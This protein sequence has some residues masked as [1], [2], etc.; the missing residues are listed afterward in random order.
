MFVVDAIG[1]QY[2]IDEGLRDRAGSLIDMF[3]DEIGYIDLDKIIFLRMTGAPKAN[4]MGKCMYIGRTPMNIIPKFVAHRLFAL[5]LLDLSNTSMANEDDIDLFD[6]RYIIIINDDA[7]QQGQG[8]LQKIEDLTL[9]HELMHIHPDENK[10]VRH[11]IEDFKIIVDK[12]GP[13]WT[14]GIFKEE[15]EGDE[16]TGEVAPEMPIMPT[17]PMSATDEWKPPESD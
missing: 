6:L 1:A 13:Y 4:W 8:D 3:Y 16:A 11:D 15:E 10:L 17:M 5:G 2:A 14:E 12:F 7:V 9:Y